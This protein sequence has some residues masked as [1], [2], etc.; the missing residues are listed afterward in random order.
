MRLPL[1][2]AK[3]ASGMRPSTGVLVRRKS[4]GKSGPMTRYPGPASIWTEKSS[5]AGRPSRLTAARGQPARSCRPANDGVSCCLCRGRVTA[6][7]NTAP[8][9]TT[10]NGSG[11]R[12]PK[13][14]YRQAPALRTDERDQIR[15]TSARRSSESGQRRCCTWAVRW[16]LYWGELDEQINPR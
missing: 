12:R 13:Q 9:P 8:R 3:F 11:V 14:P 7:G 16:T 5:S 4:P 2:P 10:Y 6:H 1:T 15:R